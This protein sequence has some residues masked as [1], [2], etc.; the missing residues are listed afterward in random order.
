LSA[1]RGTYLALLAGCV[2]V[3]LPLEV[4]LGAR[5]YRQPRRLLGTLAP[6]AAAFA[7]WDVAAIRAGWWRYDE[8]QTCG[9]VLPGDLPLEEALFFVVVPVCSILTLEA[10]RRRRPAWPIGD[11]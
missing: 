3:T 10:V 6:V 5:V 4:G 11:E 2:G 9:V 7:A 1:R 8:R